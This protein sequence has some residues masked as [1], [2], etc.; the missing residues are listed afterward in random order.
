MHPSAPEFLQFFPTLQCNQHCSF[1][2]NRGIPHLANASA[3]T[4]ALIASIAAAEGI[5][6]IDILGG[7]PTLHPELDL[8]I[9]TS[10]GKGLSITLSTNGS[11]VPLL[12][13]FSV[14][15]EGS[16][17][18]IGVSLNDTPASAALH[19]YIE[20]RGPYVKSIFGNGTAPPGSSLPY[21][22]MPGIHYYLLYRDVVSADDLEHS[23]PFHKFHEN[24]EAVKARYASIEGVFCEGFIASS[25]LASGLEHVRCPAG[26]T[27]LSVLP[28]G[29]VYP[30]YLLFRHAEF[31]IGNLLED[32]F[33]DLWKSPVLDWFRRFEGNRCPDRECALFSRCHGGCPAASLLFY[34]DPGAPDPRCIR[35]GIS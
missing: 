3:S 5:G 25:P 30:C 16:P 26:T 2:F 27:K 34:G 8:L 23:S 13:R 12:E 4:F 18:R 10:L 7:E 14:K 19:A 1:C 6:E 24:L 9:E 28:D 15:Y 21:I 35:P 33:R 22:N 32:N 11:N 31:R 17:L 20:R 29:S